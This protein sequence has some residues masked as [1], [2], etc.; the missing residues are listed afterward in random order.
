MPSTNTKPAH[1]CLNAMLQSP[2]V[3]M[4]MQ[5][6]TLSATQFVATPFCMSA[7]CY[8]LC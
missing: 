2:Q 3:N 7:M 1:S 8:T 4:Y 6:H 5:N